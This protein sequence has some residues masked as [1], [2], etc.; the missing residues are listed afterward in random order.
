MS[1]DVTRLLASMDAGD[2]ESAAGLLPL[3]YAELRQLA[4]DRMARER[5]G[6]TL[7]ATALVHEAYLRLVGGEDVARWDGR[8]H[9]F[10]AAAE[11]MRRILIDRAR[12]KKAVKHG[13]LAVRQPL[14]PDEV[15]AD[16]PDN[17][18]LA[19][20]EALVRLEAERPDHARLVKLRYFA[21]LTMRDA[22]DAMNISVATAERRWAYARAWLRV[23]VGGAAPPSDE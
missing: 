7:D 20:D 8:R 1:S 22:A 12:R 17:E 9:F 11:A 21:G 4:G 10:A 15:A 18:L 2:A 19:I 23:S 14:D 6:Q 5:P 13:G 16:T 3:V